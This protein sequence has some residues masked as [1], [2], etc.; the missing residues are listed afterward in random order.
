MVML[1]TADGIRRHHT[2]FEAAASMDVYRCL[3]LGT[4]Q[5]RLLFH[6]VALCKA[7]GILRIPLVAVIPVGMAV[8]F[9]FLADQFLFI[10]GRI[11]DMVF[12]QGADQFS[13]CAVAGPC[14]DMHFPIRFSAADQLL[15]ASVSVNMTLGYCAD[16]CGAVAVVAMAVTAL[17]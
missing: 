11:M 13:L 6:Q 3:G 2:G 15:I 17:C 12:V 5:H 4:D 9:F 8:P 10:A 1:H 16:G 14:V 7:A